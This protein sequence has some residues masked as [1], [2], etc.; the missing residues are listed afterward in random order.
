MTHSDPQ[1]DKPILTHHER[2]QVLVEEYCVL[3]DLLRFRLEAMD[4]R[5]PLAGGVLVTALSAL[6]AMPSETQ[7]VLLLTLPAAVLWLARMTIAHGRS[8]EDLKRR[9]AQLERLINAIAGEELLVF[10]SRHPDAF[11]NVGG[12]TGMATVWAVFTL[13]LAMLGSC[14]YLFALSRPPTWLT[15]IYLAFVAWSA[16][17]LAGQ[18]WALGG[19]RYRKRPAENKNRNHTHSV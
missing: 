11:A 6:S 18:V 2:I 4:A 10:Q 16:V 13:C 5:L 3:Y 19:Y 15:G 8:K 1:A 12:R 17:H 7:Q 9:I 14:A